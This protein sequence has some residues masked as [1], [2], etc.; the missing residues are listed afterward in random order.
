[1]V[2]KRFGSALLMTCFL[3]CLASF[4]VSAQ[5]ETG[6]LH[7]I[8]SPNDFYYPWTLTDS[9]G[10]TLGVYAGS[11]TVTG[12]P[13]GYIFIQ[14]DEAYKESWTMSDPSSPDS[15]LINSVNPEFTYQ[16]TFTRNEGIISISPSIPDAP[17]ILYQPDGST[18]VGTGSARFEHSI[19]GDYFVQWKPV[20]DFITPQD[21]SGTLL[22]NQTLDLQGIYQPRSDD[23]L[24]APF[25]WMNNFDTTQTTQTF[26]SIDAI[27]VNSSGKC[28]ATGTLNEGGLAIASMDV[29]TGKPTII[30]WASSNDYVEATA[31]SIREDGTFVVAGIY[32][33][34]LTFDPNSSTPTE[35][36]ATGN[37][38][39]TFIAKYDS[40]GNRLFL[41]TITGGL[42]QKV[43]RI[44]ITRNGPIYIC[45]VFEGTVFFGNK[46][47]GLSTVPVWMASQGEA[48][49]FVLSYRSDGVINW[50]SSFGGTHYI[51]CVGMDMLQKDASLVITGNFSSDIYYN[52]S[53]IL[54]AQGDQSN[55]Y[56]CKLNASRGTLDWIRQETPKEEAF[57]YSL[58][59]SQDQTEFIIAGAFK[60]TLS[61]SHTASSEPSDTTDTTAFM[62]LT[63][64]GGSDLYTAKY[65]VSGE[66]I[67]ARRDGG[68]ADEYPYGCGI[69][70]DNSILVGGM[71]SGTASFAID[72]T[73]SGTTITLPSQGEND[74]FVI[75]IDENGKLYKAQASGSIK[76][77]VVSC[78]VVHNIGSRWWLAGG[79]QSTIK[80]KN[81]NDD[82]TSFD[83]LIEG[84][85]QPFIGRF[86]DATM[87]D[88]GIV[89]IEV[90]PDTAPWIIM[91]T[92][93]HY[94][95][96]GT[97]PSTI[98]GVPYGT[99][100]LE[101][102]T[103][104]G[105]EKPE[106][107]PSQPLPSGGEITFEGTYTH[108]NQIL[109][110]QWIFY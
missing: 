97:G 49:G 104:E 61:F 86:G 21:S 90:T 78:V 98:E 62:T 108:T 91:N 60:D 19:I 72:N 40:R 58:A 80:F 33:G 15:V 8:I 94:L 46:R 17:W 102:G 84:V 9:E 27:D 63:S 68:T 14:F 88:V 42:R 95:N 106:N 18:R 100:S 11:Q 35:L 3:S 96:T 103:L 28:I 2:H 101:W 47:E 31:T 13:Y 41:Q 53:F 48:N 87:V 16:Y 109:P 39:E 12:L 73:T 51:D 30:D 38:P 59:S 77:D 74:A 79:H 44:H 85:E 81:T 93:Q 4:N 20:L 32:T 76:N 56:V 29:N 5:D 1:M 105:W 26:K 65:N 36:I 37:W 92:D 110:S 107:P 70:N 99:I 10:T 75:M 52:Q 82:I 24:I 69:F 43:N 54:K 55:A 23:Y 71:Y 57:P 67:W 64:N 34:K 25:V 6:T 45:G 89:V 66:L 7:I 22:K 83:T 50:A